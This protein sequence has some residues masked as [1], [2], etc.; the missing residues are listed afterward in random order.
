MCSSDLATTTAPTNVE[1]DTLVNIIGVGSR[2]TD[3]NLQVL[4]ND[5]TGTATAVDLGV[6]FPANGLS[7]DTYELT[8][9]CS[10]N[11]SAVNYRVENQQN[12]TVSTG[13]INTNLPASTTLL[14][15]QAYR[16]NNATA[17]AVGI[18]LVS[19]Y[20]ETNY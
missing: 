18:D 7:S 17:L 14:G 12:S 11:D 6:N 4:Y 15:F 20:V 10:P 13:T 2:S 9:Y 3:T 19:L 5:A 16:S 8:L 1:T